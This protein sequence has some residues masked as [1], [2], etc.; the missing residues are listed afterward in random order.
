M[1]EAASGLRRIRGDDGPGVFAGSS[2]P[3][4]AWGPGVA[5]TVADGGEP[6]PGPG[7]AATSVAARGTPPP[8]ATGAVCELYRAHYPSLVRMAALLVGDLAAAEQVVQDSLVA[9]HANWRWLKRRDKALAFVRRGVINRSRSA[10][11]HRGVDEPDAGPPLA[12]MPGAAPDAQAQLTCAPVVAALGRLS[13]RQREAL[14]LRYYADLSEA[15]TASAMGI[16]PGAVKSHTARAML[17]I[18]DA[19]EPET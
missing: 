5:V 19:L 17:A 13:R 15:E 14:V 12:Q 11:R 1:G 18:G 6:A 16:S 9:M 8:D 10:L 4:G 7:D 2:P 3:G